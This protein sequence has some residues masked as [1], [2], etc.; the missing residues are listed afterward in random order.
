[1]SRS[2]APL[3]SR[4][5]LIRGLFAL[6]LVATIAACGSSGGDDVATATTAAGADAPT[7]AAAGSDGTPAPEAAAPEGP[8]PDACGLL[9]AADVEAVLGSAVEPSPL[10]GE[11]AD[12]YSGCLWNDLP[13]L[14]GVQVAA[15]ADGI[16]ALVALAKVATEAPLDSPVGRDG[17]YY[18]GTGFVPGGGGVGQSVLFFDGPWTVVVGVAGTPDT[19]IDRAVLEDLAAKVE[20]AVS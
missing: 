8:A 3:R 4:S 12:N 10:P 20:A 6:A 15:P 9:T 1:M 17:L 2:D 7:S 14:L 5:P 18:P 11:T 19:P 16:D 13:V